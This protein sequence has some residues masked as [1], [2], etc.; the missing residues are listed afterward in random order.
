M[1]VLYLNHVLFDTVNY[2]SEYIDL[3]IDILGMLVTLTPKQI[4]F[5]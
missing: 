3:S 2:N 4:F 5:L 1:Y